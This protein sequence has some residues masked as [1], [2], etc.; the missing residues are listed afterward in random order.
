MG[1]GTSIGAYYDDDFNYQAGVTPPPKDGVVK[2]KAGDEDM[3]VS[4]S[5]PTRNR[6]LDDLEMKS[7]GTPVSYELDNREGEDHT[8]VWKADGTLNK[9]GFGKAVRDLAVST[10]NYLW[11]TPSIP[12]APVSDLSRALGHEDIKLGGEIDRPLL[13]RAIDDVQAG[14]NLLGVGKGESWADKLTKPDGFS[15]GYTALNK[16]FGTGDVE[17][18]QLWPEKMLR[19]G[20]NAAYNIAEG[21]KSMWAFDPDSGEFRTSVDGLESAHELMP[22]ILS[23]TIP[24]RISLKETKPSAQEIVARDEQSISQ[25]AIAQVRRQRSNIEEMSHGE[26]RAILDDLSIPAAA[27][28]R[29]LIREEDP[30][31]PHEIDDG[32]GANPELFT[33][34][35]RAEMESVYRQEPFRDDGFEPFPQGYDRDFHTTIEH[36]PQYS[37]EVR[38][39]MQGDKLKLIKEDTLRNGKTHLFK[40]ANKDGVGELTINERKN[41]RE[42]YVSWIGTSGKHDSPGTFGTKA[43]KEFFREVARE[44]PK[45]EAV[46]GFRV[47]GAR[48]KTGKG[49]AD[50]IMEI[51]GRRQGRRR[52][53]ARKSEETRMYE[54]MEEDFNNPDMLTRGQ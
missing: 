38:Q 22:F 10:G 33:R 21:K 8:N 23:G 27:E 35:E 42:L 49:S 39:A 24:G 37:V 29:G 48:Q 7:L 2:P 11:G 12:E 13:S 47:S 20:I 51:P 52:E 16:I 43:I 14:A 3:E 6:E 4:P 45:A 17:R 25:Q 46:T 31:A 28:R 30:R 40:F 34:A 15:K 54:Q 26:Q 53:E 41:G 1:V 44:F 19:A 9:E 36:G 32:L 50:A 5:S 18:Y